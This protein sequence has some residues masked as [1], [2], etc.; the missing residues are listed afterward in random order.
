MFDALLVQQRLQRWGQTPET[1][2]D[3]VN[4]APAFIERVGIATL[5]P[6]SPEFPNLYSA[7][8]GDPDAKTDSGWKTPSGEV[9]TW[10]WTLGRQS[11]AFYTTLIRK[12]PTWIRWSLLPAV[13]RLC[14]TQQSAEELYQS[15]HLS[16]DAHRIY[17]TLEASS[18]ALATPELREQAGFPRGSGARSA[19]LKGVEELETHLLLA[20]VFLA[21][22]DTMHHTLISTRYPDL[23]AIAETLSFEAALDQFLQAYL[24]QAVYANPTR[25]A[26]DLKIPV[27]ALTAAFERLLDTHQVNKIPLS[28]NTSGY[29]WSDSAST[30]TQH[31]AS[32]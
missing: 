19:Y 1:H 4:E 7:Y 31:I 6:A 22:G 29:D 16:T 3:G 18:G 5:Y 32:R 11:T 20:K 2:L 25:L 17:Q 24:P 26:K 30:T 12:R 15:G 27:A 10:R 9:Y 23:V 21:D 14:G 28:G 13:L 8:V